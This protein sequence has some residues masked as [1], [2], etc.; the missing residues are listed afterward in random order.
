MFEKGVDSI[1]LS[2]DLWVHYMDYVVDTFRAEEEEDYVRMAFDRAVRAC[3]MDYRYV[4]ESATNVMLALPPVRRRFGR[5]T[6]PGSER[7][8][9]GCG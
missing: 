9:A 8:N 7:G 1:P 6:C 3:G 2:V 5:H 4:L